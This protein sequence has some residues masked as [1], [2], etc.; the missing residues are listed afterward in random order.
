MGSWRESFPIIKGTPLMGASVMIIGPTAIASEM[1]TQ[2]AERVITDGHGHFSIEHLVPGWYSL[3]VSSPT[4]VPAMRDG[5]RVD[6]GETTIAGFVLTE[7]FAPVRLQVP[8]NSVSTWGDDWKWV[9]RTSSTT[10]PILRYREQQQATNVSSAD[11]ESSASYPVYVWSAAGF[12]S[13]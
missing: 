9:L 4:R 7:I 13:A 11:P 10:R 8:N 3:K 6:A 12:A 1:A 2:S 5:I